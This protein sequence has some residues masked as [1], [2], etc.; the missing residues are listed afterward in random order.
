VA[1]F[2]ASLFGRPFVCCHG[3]EIAGID[4]GT[5]PRLLFYLLLF[6]DRLHAREKLALEFWP[7]STARVARKNLRQA[8]WQ[9]GQWLPGDG[10]TLLAVESEWVGL[11]EQVNCLVDTAVFEGIFRRV[12]GIHGRDLS[13]EA[14]YQIKQAVAVYRGDL[15]E[16]WPEEWC[17]YE[18]ERF[19]QMYLTLLDKLVAYSEAKA[20][21]E[22]GIYYGGQILRHD[23]AHER[24]HRRIMRMQ[25]LAGDRTAALRQFGECQAALL[26]ELNVVPAQ[27]TLVLYEQIRDD[28]LR[29]AGG[30]FSREPDQLPLILEDLQQIRRTLHE[31]QRLL[32]NDIRFMEQTIQEGASRSAHS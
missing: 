16:G 7:D 9:L 5:A 3:H 14:I 1:K 4:T 30:Y 13:P 2:E 24:T 29:P 8:L 10:E 27:Q 18:R 12:R 21:Y 25:A 23:H 20:A 32:N 15:L 26:K 17:L 11:N 28:T 19:K 22:E 6:C 31:L